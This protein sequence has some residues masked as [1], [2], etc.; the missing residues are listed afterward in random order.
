MKNRFHSQ[1]KEE[2]ND[3]RPINILTHSQDLALS[4]KYL[5]VFMQSLEPKIFDEKVD[6]LFY[7]FIEYNRT[8]TFSLNISSSRYCMM[9][10]KY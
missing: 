7:Y 10:S 3:L 2:L 4:N 6:V 5:E 8:S 9:T 1:L